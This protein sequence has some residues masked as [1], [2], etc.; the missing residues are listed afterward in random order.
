MSADDDGSNPSARGRATIVPVRAK[1]AG[2]LI[3]VIAAAVPLIVLG[4]ALVVLLIP[5]FAHF[6]YAMPG[7]PADPFGL[8]GSAREDL[9]GLGIRSIW[10]VGPGPDLL[11]DARLPDGTLAFSRGEIRHMADVRDLVR[12][13]F[14]LWLAAL[15]AAAAAAWGLGR[16]RRRDDI[17][18]GL[19]I[20]AAITVVALAVAGL[21]MAIDFEAVFDGFHRL[22]FEEGT[23][24]FSDDETLRRLYPDAFWGI[25]AGL[26]AG[27]AVAQAAGLLL[28]SRRRP[29]SGTGNGGS[30]VERPQADQ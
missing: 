9:G 13:S 4:N 5:W 2:L 27:L 16:V 29:Q 20:G 6:Q 22:L 10:P 12:V 8:A 24:T 1:P 15:A 28:W 3:A 26:F 14:A 19:G 7:F 21:A 18:R 11:V 17:R 30:A 25:A 23:W